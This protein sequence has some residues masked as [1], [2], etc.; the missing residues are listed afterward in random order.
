VELLEPPKVTREYHEP[1]TQAFAIGNP[2]KPRGAKAKRTREGEAF[3]RAWC[4]ANAAA[5]LDEITTDGDIDQKFRALQFFFDHAHGKPLQRVEVDL[6][7][8]A[9]RMAAMVGVSAEEL[10]AKAEE[11][12]AG[13]PS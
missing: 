9:Q 12:V 2:G 10:L 11:I 13:E 4:D 6:E 1:G 8:E 3:A 7:A 5:I